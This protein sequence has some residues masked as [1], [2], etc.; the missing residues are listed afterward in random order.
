MIL[1][2]PQITWLALLAFGVL[3]SIAKDGKPRTGNHN[4]GHDMIAYVISVWLVYM[5][6]FFG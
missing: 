2:W 5:G 3:V 6:G 1:H 4:L